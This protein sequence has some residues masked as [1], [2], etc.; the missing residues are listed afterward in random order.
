MQF[1][2]FFKNFFVKL[3]LIFKNITIFLFSKKILKIIFCCIVLIFLIFSPAIIFNKDKYQLDLNKYLNLNNNK[4][5]V[6]T[7]W[8]VESFEGGTN[9]RE[10]YLEKQAIKFNKLNNNCFINIE[11]M[12]EEQLWLNLKENKCPDIFSF[13]TGVGY[14]LSSMLTSL[15]ENNAIREDLKQYCM[16]SKDIMAYPFL[17]SGYCAITKEIYNQGNQLL[18]EKKFNNIIKNKKEIKGI[19]FSQTSFN[20]ISQVLIKNG[21]ESLKEDNLYSCNSTYEAYTNFLSNKFIT[22]IGTARDVARCKNRESNG[23]LSCCSYEF[24]GGFS[25]LIQFVGVCKNSSKE[26]KIYAK[27]FA[28]F[29]TTETCQKDI[30]NYGLFS[31]TNLS[32]YENGY[33]VEFEKVLKKELTSINAFMDIQQINKQKEISFKNLFKN[34]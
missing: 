4:K 12:S 25:D 3:F 16:I 28:K 1:F 32:L 24:L 9:S 5:I 10:K 30:K 22:L 19:G 13:G 27:S 11:T 21:V 15:G 18:K 26:R 7:I 17:L 23:N 14:M 31:T 20:D 33:M 8:H 29:L 2:I 6:L 34:N